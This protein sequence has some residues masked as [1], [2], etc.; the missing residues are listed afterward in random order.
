MPLLSTLAG[1]RGFGRLFQATAPANAY[2]WLETAIVG[3]GGTSSVTFSNLN[4]NY[5]STYQHL[6]LR[7]VG[8]TNR[9]D[10]DD[11]LTINFNGDTGNNYAS[12]RL[13]ANGLDVESSAPRTSYSRIET[14]SLT[15][16]T[17]TANSFGAMVIDILDPF[18]TT[19]NTTVKTIAG[20]TGSYRFVGLSSGLWMNTNAINS[21]LIDQFF[22]SLFAEH[23]RFSLYGLRRS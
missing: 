15:A 20:L 2:E 19:K 22:G 17:Q 5:G 3:A 11:F 13:R 12:H 18:E 9:N 1:A 23:S 14:Y 7:I 21:I 4:T 16:S 8:R 10:T 6:Q